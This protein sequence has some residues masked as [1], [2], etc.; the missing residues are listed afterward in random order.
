MCITLTDSFVLQYCT[1]L[2]DRLILPVITLRLR[3]NDRHFADDIFKRIF[4][5]ENVWISI[6]I[7]STFVAKGL[8]NNIAAVVQPDSGLLP[9]RRQATI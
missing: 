6:N 8:I 7:S 1:I 3:Q 4:L 2:S 9:I 5:S